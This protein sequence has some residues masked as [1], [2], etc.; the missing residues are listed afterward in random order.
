MSRESGDMCGYVMYICYACLYMHDRHMG[1]AFTQLMLCAVLFD[2]GTDGGTLVS[3]KNAT[4]HLAG[5]VT[6]SRRFREE[7]QGWRTHRN[8]NLRRLDRN[9]EQCKG[10]LI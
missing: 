2:V 8:L 10:G 1:T 3:L 6:H 4:S 5:C 9:V 7:H